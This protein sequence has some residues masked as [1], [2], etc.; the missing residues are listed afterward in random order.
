[1][2]VQRTRRTSTLIFA[3]VRDI[4]LARPV[5]HR[6]WPLTTRISLHLT[7]LA[8]VLLYL[9]HWFGHRYTAKF[10]ID[11]FNA[12]RSIKRVHISPLASETFSPLN[13]LGSKM[14]VF[15]C[16]YNFF[17]SSRHLVDVMA[18]MIRSQMCWQEGLSPAA[19]LRQDYAQSG[20]N[21]NAKL[22]RITNNK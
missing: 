18:I 9:T 20:W 17:L 7:S 12:N 19:I 6:S 8:N 22:L 1:M 13:I 5:W 14:F 11:C 21:T 16:F 2:S 3:L 10:F 15:V 4:Q